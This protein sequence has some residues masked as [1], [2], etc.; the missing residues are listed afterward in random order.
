MTLIWRAPI[1]T[2]TQTI[3]MY[4]MQPPQCNYSRNFISN[5][6]IQQKMKTANKIFIINNAAIPL[7]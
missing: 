1:V 2:V 4:P 3:Y 5:S 6:N 7:C